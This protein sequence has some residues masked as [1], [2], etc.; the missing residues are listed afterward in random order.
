MELTLFPGSP[1]T[2]T[3]NQEERREPGKIY[4]M[5]NVIGKEDLL[6]VGEQMNLPMLYGQSTLVPLQKLYGWHMGTRQHYQAVRQAMVSVFKAYI[7]IQKP[8]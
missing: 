5:R 7:Y 8:R 6:Q 4:R 1:R 2:W 3:K